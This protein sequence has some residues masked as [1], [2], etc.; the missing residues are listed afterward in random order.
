M[1]IEQRGNAA[2]DRAGDEVGP[3][4]RRLPHRHRRH[5]E[6]ERHDRVD[7]DRHRDDGDGHDLHRRFEAVPLFRRAAPAERERAIDPPPQPG[8]AVAGDREVRN[9]RQEQEQQAAGEI[10][11]DGE[12]VPD[13]RRA[14]VR[15][16]QPL[17]RV[18]KQPEREPRP[19][20]MDDRKQRA[21]HQREHRDDF[22]AAR[23]RPAPA[24][25]HQ[26]ED[27]RD[28]RSRRG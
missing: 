27:G 15:P 21:D 28:Q 4:D 22:G 16:D 5:R 9:D 7:G 13:E 19:P 1:A 23:H 10:G 3:E 12:E 17:A 11:V 26:P 18:R 14:E 24:R 25:V 8:G 20:E 2:E 6:V